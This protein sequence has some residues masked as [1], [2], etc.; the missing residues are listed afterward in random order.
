M[1][2]EV[3]RVGTKRESGTR[4]EQ[5]CPNRLLTSRSVFV[6]AATSR[7]VGSTHTILYCTI[8]Y[9]TLGNDH[10]ECIDAGCARAYTVDTEQDRRG[11]SGLADE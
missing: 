4:K 7:W 8:P 2:L 6:H 10:E 9:S 3:P 11:Q 5:S 1:K